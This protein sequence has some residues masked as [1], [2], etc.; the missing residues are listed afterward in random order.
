M[1]EPTRSQVRSRI[2]DSGVVAVLR[3]IEAGTAVEVAEAL[4]AGGVD[5][6]EVTADT[7]GAI[8]MV[9]D[10]AT[11]FDDP[12]VVV[13]AGTVLDSETATAAIRAGAEF[14]VSPTLEPDVIETANRY[15]A[16]SAPGVLTPTEALSAVEYGADLVK[17]FPAGSVGPEYVASIRGP[18]DQLPIVPTGGVDLDNAADFIEAGAVAVGVGSALV[19][20]RAIAEGD[21][22]VLTETARAFVETVDAA[23]QAEP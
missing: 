4:H 7:P 1:N 9:A 3:G 8:E 12:E 2:V 16:V 15:G 11:A 20:D 14:V 5:A 6:I 23:R 21:Y 13:G 22:D 10:L 19:D 17:V 18:L